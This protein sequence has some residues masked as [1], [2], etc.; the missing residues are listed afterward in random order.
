[1]YRTILI[2]TDGFD[3]DFLLI[4]FLKKNIFNNY[5]YSFGFFF[6]S[7]EMIGNNYSEDLEYL[8]VNWDEFKPKIQDS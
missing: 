8:K 4:E 7:S 5:N 3:E 6:I 2:F 1:M